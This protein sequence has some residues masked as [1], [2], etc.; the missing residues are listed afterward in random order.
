MNGKLIGVSI[1]GERI[2]CQPDS[3]LELEHTP[4][5][6]AWTTIPHQEGIDFKAGD[7]IDSVEFGG[8]VFTGAVREIKAKEVIIY[9]YI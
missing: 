8:Q 4:Q 9:L 6:V 3:V 5:P 2:D 1:N 7:K